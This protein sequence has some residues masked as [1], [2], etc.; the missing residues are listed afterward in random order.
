M[1]NFSMIKA[2]HAK[3]DVVIPDSLLMLNF[4]IGSN[5]E[6]SIDQPYYSSP[7]N[8]LESFVE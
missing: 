1:L 5:P 8:R 4:L 3:I 6:L 7:S 2:I